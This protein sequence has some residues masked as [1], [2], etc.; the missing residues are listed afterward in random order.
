M[1][2]QIH[3]RHGRTSEIFNI[4]E[5]KLKDQNNKRT[6]QSILKSKNKEVNL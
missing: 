1:K 2:R 5:S 6:I 3:T 4:L